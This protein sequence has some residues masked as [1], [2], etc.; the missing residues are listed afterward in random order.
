MAVVAGAYA[1]NV[2]ENVLTNLSYDAR[3]QAFGRADELISD[4]SEWPFIAR[5]GGGLGGAGANLTTEISDELAKN[6]DKELQLEII[7]AV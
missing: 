6:A 5:T 2:L 3:D 7:P 1:A 4:Y